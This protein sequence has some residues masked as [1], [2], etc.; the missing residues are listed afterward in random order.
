MPSLMYHFLVELKERFDMI[1]G[2]SDWYQ[3]QICLA[4]LDI[5]LHSIARLGP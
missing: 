2:E 4:L 3:Y 1:A 5:F